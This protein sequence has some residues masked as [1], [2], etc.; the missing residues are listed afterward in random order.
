MSL[1][2]ATV[3]TN[4]L[5]AIPW[6]GTDLTQFSTTLI[7][8]VVLSITAQLFISGGLPTIGVLKQ[9]ALMIRQ[10]LGPY[11]KGK[12]LE[13]PYSFLSMFVGL[14]DGDG[15]IGVNR[16]T[17]GYIQITLNLRL[18]IADLPTLQYVHSV[19]Q[20]GSITTHNTTAI[21]TIYRVDLQ[22]ILFPLLIH[23]GLFFLTN[24]RRLQFERAMYVLNTGITLYSDIPADVR[25]M[26]PVPLTAVEYLGLPFF[27]NWVVGFTI[28]EGS[29]H[30][31]ANGDFCF[32]LK[33]RPHLVL[34]EALQLLFKTRVKIHTSDGYNT[35]VMTS[36]KD[37]TTVVSFFS[38]S[39]LHPLTG[40]KLNS[41]M[42]WI[43]QM[44]L[45][46]RFK[47]LQLP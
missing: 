26:N 29:F 21:Y 25:T 38:F 17:S 47:D 27:A 5:S 3:I 37:L 42:R 24:A 34:F 41:Y 44:K 45:V 35:L 22:Q 46:R 8:Y 39:G 43:E 31:K 11:D 6:I 30:I 40:L 18:D 13:I 7:Y 32:S 33:Q 2:G 28:A 23:H 16:D 1:W 15:Y 36:V 12:W 4:M 14:I 9:K 20:I 19:L 10:V